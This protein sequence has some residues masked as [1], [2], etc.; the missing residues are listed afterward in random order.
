MKPAFI[1]GIYATEQATTIINTP[2]NTL[3]RDKESDFI[4]FGSA[5]P[6]FLFILR[7]SPAGK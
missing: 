5:K 7:F 2:A 3:S 6:L 1:A 4:L